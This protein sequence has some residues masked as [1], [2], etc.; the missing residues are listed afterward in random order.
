VI[1]YTTENGATS[2]DLFSNG[3]FGDNTTCE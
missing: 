1:G 3:D 2:S